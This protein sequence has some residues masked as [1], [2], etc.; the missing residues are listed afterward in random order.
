MKIALIRRRYSPTGGAERYLERLAAHLVMRGHEVALWTEGW[1]GQGSSIKDVNVVQSSDPE[2]FA[3]QIQRQDL[4]SRYQLVFSLERIE[5][6]DLYRAGDGIHAEWMQLRARYSPIRGRIANWLKLKNNTMCALE[7]RM[8]SPEATGSI[9]ANSHHVAG[10][11]AK[12]FAYPADRIH[13]VY[14]GIPYDHFANGGDRAR[15]RKH[16][17]WSDNEYIIALVGKGRERKGTSYAERAVARCG[18]KNARLA[19][20][21]SAPASLMPHIYA[22]ADIFLLPTLYDPFSN[23]TL[24]ALAAGLPVITTCHNGVSEVMSHGRDGFVLPAADAVPAMSDLIRRL[25]DAD[26]RAALRAPAQQLASRFTI[27]R[28]VDET[29]RVC[30]AV[31]RS[32]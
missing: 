19:I 17:G 13:V 30:M 5:G 27:E 9:I 28:N 32:P 20:V 31:A 11:I 8:F 6:C 23:A 14:N 16:M 25:A 15:G 24:E 26:L 4:R 1:E 3:K 29:L 2:G 7:R 22:A 21:D 18:V 12:R 10:E